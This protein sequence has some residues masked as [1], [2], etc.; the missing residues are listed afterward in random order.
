VFTEVFG[1]GFSDA[2]PSAILLESV[3]NQNNPF[4][5]TQRTADR[6]VQIPIAEKTF[7]EALNIKV[8]S[9]SELP[10]L[11]VNFCLLCIHSM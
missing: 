1:E 10:E 4:P 2:A 9:D 5:V 8:I 6:R 7:I 3:V 11:D